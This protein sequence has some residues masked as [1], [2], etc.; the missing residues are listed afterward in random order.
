MSQ[1]LPLSSVV[2]AI[3]ITDFGALDLG[4]PGPLCSPTPVM[5]ECFWQTLLL[6]FA[7]QMGYAHGPKT[8]VD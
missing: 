3:Q 5:N 8:R 7:I 2:T 4:I 1:Q 6:L